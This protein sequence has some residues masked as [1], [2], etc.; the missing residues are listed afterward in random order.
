MALAWNDGRNRIANSVNQFRSLRRN[1][2]PMGRDEVAVWWL[3]TEASGPADRHRWLGMLDRDE[4]DRA[5]RFRLELDR[6]E[7]IA[8]HALLRSILTYYLDQPAA[9]W[10]FWT[11]ANGKPVLAG[12]MGLPEFQ[13]NISHTRGLVAATVAFHCKLGIDVEKI[14]RAKVDFSVAEKYFAPSEIAM[15]RRTPEPERPLWFFRLWTVKEAYLKAIGTGL[16]TSLDSFA[17][18]FDPIRIRFPS[19]RDDPNHWYFEMPPASDLH[20]LSLAIGCP[21]NTVRV[22][23]RAVTPDEI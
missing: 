22:V 10:R 2:R 12:E 14:D 9:A 3:A 7:F 16:G 13:F 11:D 21:S 4:R 6:R 15:L 19:A 18:A 23:P 20:V 8:A 17:V 1:A 5:A